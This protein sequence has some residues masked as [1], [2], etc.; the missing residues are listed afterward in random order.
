MFVLVSGLS[1][2]AVTERQVTP[3]MLSVKQCN[4]HLCGMLIDAGSNLNITDD[5]NDTALDLSVYA[6]CER[7]THLL[8]VNGADMHCGNKG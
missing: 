5:N 6:G 8:I 7:N 1:V 4:T 2:N 3:L